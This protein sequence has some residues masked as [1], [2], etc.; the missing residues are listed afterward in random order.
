MGSWEMG[1]GLGEGKVCKRN[2]YRAIIT[3]ETYYGPRPKEWLC[4]WR[5]S[6]EVKR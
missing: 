3:G 5:G 4:E 1:E 6:G 2:G